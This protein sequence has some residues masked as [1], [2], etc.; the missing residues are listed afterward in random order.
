MSLQLSCEDVIYW[1]YAI[2]V[3]FSSEDVIYWELCHVCTLFWLDIN[4]CGFFDHMK[5]HRKLKMNI[6]IKNKACIVCSQ[7]NA[8]TYPSTKF[9]CF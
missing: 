3:Q 4:F 7:Q 6:N 8:H 1:N 5:W 9:F 2:S